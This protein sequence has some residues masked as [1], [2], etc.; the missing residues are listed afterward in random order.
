MISHITASSR[1]KAEQLYAVAVNVLVI[2]DFRVT[3]LQ[4]VR[5]P[6]PHLP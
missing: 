5:T 6:D 2:F 4:G 1:Y 3:V